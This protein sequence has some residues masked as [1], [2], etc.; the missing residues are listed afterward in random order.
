MAAGRT[1]GRG[2]RP[3]A[4]AVADR[5]PGQA[6]THAVGPSSSPAQGP[7]AGPSRAAVAGPSLARAA[8]Q[9]GRR[10]AAPGADPCGE[11]RVAL[12]ADQVAPGDRPAGLPEAQPSGHRQDRT[13]SLAGDPCQDRR[14]APAADHASAAGDRS[15]HRPAAP[16]ADHH[17]DRQAFPVGG[18]RG[19]HASAAGDRSTHRPAAPPADHRED[20][21]AS[22]AGGPCQDRPAAPAAGPCQDRRAAPA[23]DPASAARDRSAH[24][25]AAPPADHHWGRHAS[26]PA[27]RCGDHAIAARGRSAGQAERRFED[28]QRDLAYR[29]DLRRSSDGA[30]SGSDRRR[31]C[32]DRAPRAPADLRL[33]CFPSSSGSAKPRGPAERDHYIMGHRPETPLPGRRWSRHP[34]W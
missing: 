34:P 24:R 32:A 7:V 31:T 22:P 29:R 28:R 10:R 20:R 12:S 27:G 8:D 11:R 15:A 18:H 6:G 4:L 1:A 33:S 5:S 23:A 17:G 30:G 21:N 9:C 26:P 2:R 13:A 14:A 25:P 19:D 16:P 3:A